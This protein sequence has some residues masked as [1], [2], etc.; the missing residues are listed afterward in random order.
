MVF[1][2]R[3]SLYKRIEYIVSFFWGVD[4]RKPNGRAK[5]W[6]LYQGGLYIKVVFN[7]GSTVVDNIKATTSGPHQFSLH[8]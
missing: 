7:Q 5:K 2:A 3:W 6:S 1:I 4:I 8:C